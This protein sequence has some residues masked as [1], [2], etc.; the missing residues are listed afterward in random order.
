MAERYLGHEMPVVGPGC[1]PGCRSGW[2]TRARSAPT[3]SSTPSPRTSA[4][5]APCVVV[6]FG[7]A[8]TYDCVGPGGE[9]IGGI[10]APGVEISME[11]LTAARRRSRGSTSPRRAR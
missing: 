1:G 4:S 10:I 6:D 8:I 7:T 2:T 11:A 5:A 3:G 9:Y